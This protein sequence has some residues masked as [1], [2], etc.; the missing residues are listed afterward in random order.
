YRDE[1]GE[2]DM[3]EQRSTATDPNHQGGLGVPVDHGSRCHVCGYNLTGVA[4]STC[5]ECGARV[6]MARTIESQRRKRVRIAMAIVLGVTLL[7]NTI[8]ITQAVA[9]RSWGAMFIGLWLGP[10]TNVVVPSIACL[11]S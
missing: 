3:N 9:D 5:P 11:V 1:Q 4:S 2:P 8:L 6:D 7:V 10:I